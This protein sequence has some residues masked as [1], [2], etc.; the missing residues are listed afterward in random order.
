MALSKGFHATANCP[1]GIMARAEHRSTLLV[2]D[3]EKDITASLADLFRLDYKVITAATAM[4]A[5][6][7]LKQQEV[8]VI[9]ADQRMPEM[10]GSELLAKAS[11]LEPDT[12]RI[13]LTGYADIEAVVKAVNEGNIFFYLTKPWSNKEIQTVVAR[14]VEHNFLLRDNRRLIKELRQKNADTVK[15]LDS[16]PS[17]IVVLDLQGAIVT[18]NDAWLKYSIA[19]G[20]RP[21]MPANNTG[22]GANYLEVCLDSSSIGADGALDAYNGIR[23]VLNSDKPSF[24]MDYPCDS[25]K[26]ALWFTMIVTPLGD[27]TIEGVVVAHINVTLLKQAAEQLRVAAVAFESQEGMVITDSSC[28]ILNVN[29]AFTQ[30]SGYTKEEVVGKNPR[31][32]KSG[33][34]NAEFYREMWESIK[35]TGSW[36]GEIWDRR[37]NG[38][39][40]AKWLTISSVKNDKGILTHYVGA[41]YDI[42]DRKEFEEKIHGL[43]FYDQLTGL[44]NRTLLRERLIQAMTASVRNASYGGLLFIDLDNFKTLNDSL[45]HDMGDLLLQQVAHRLTLCVRAEDTVARLGGD[46]FVVMLT[47]LSSDQ[48]EGANQIEK[49]GEKILEALNQDYQLKDISYHSTPSIGATL[50]TGNQTE[51][52]DLMKQADIAMYRSKKSGRNTLRF[53]DP[54]MENEVMERAAHEKEL[55]NAVV[56]G[57]FLLHFQP[58]LAGEQLVG[59]EVLVRWHHPSRGLVSPAEFIPLA[60]ETGLIL[61][62]GLWVLETAC[63]QLAMW[64]TRPE[65]AHLNA[66]V[67][68][69]ARQFHQP[70]FVDQVLKV[71]A[72][73]GADPR[74]LKLEL[75]ESMLVTNVAEIIEKMFTLKALGI[76]FSLDDFGTGFS[77]LS[78]LKM[79]P[80]D[81]LKIDQSFVRDVLTDPNDAAI[82]KTV[83]ALSRSL[84]LSV[85]AEGVETAEQRDFLAD[86]GCHL[87]QGYFFS[88]PLPLSGFEQFALA[89]PGRIFP[90]TT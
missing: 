57:E 9:V 78:Y 75:T 6:T 72:T 11:A 12:V 64:A 34:H 53:F 47:N 2:V 41:H 28:L 43:A 30:I 74:K 13:L 62:L 51:L 76:G 73:T 63:R 90:K 3:D 55:R 19:N 70:D 5:L 45:G 1:A 46:E 20:T 68:V 26:E 69:S 89:R 58:Q 86:S 8:S 4:E 56:Q 15:I 67:N 88:R 85:I 31:I 77:S 35:T 22:I 44:P 23:A 10:T 54:T 38:D 61:A 27:T 60:E 36:Q 52:D 80:L 66:A 71:L 17:A 18:V 84:G 50:F 21:D 59:S 14:A 24:S 83:I 42:T 7:I 40:Y 79:M 29:K 16:L 39:E 87:Y 37:K 25:M 65:M 82:A 81:Q 49:V 32:M 33:R 48:M